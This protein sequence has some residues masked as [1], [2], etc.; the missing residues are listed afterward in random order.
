M[1]ISKTLGVKDREEWRAWLEEHHASEAEVWLVYYKKGSGK[2]RIPY[3]DAVEEAL[4]F[5]WIDSTNKD[6]GDGER[7]VQRFT[8]RRGKSGWSPMNKERARRLIAEGRMTQAGLDALGDAL[9]G[10][11]TVAEDIL[12]RLKE[13]EGVWENYEGFPE[14]YKRIRVGWIEGARNR[15]EEFEK[16]LRYFLKMT[17]K[18]KR[19][20]M[21]Q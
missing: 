15:P 7:M 13:D 3:N 9:E 20:G 18:G 21:V 11:F 8:P 5:G 6:M 1:E 12:A 2:G 10:E 17:G 19:F 4:C 14:S 16:R